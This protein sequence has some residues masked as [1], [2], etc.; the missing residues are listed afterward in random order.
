VAAG[1]VKVRSLDMRRFD[2]EVAT[3]QRVYNSAWE[4]NWGFVPMT[5]EEIAT[6]RSS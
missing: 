3:I 6:W 2:D 4:R 5:P 1:E